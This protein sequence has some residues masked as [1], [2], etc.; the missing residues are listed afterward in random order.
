MTYQSIL[1]TTR[2]QLQEF[3]IENP[4]LE[5]HEILCHCSGLTKAELFRDLSTEISESVVTEIQA[6]VK[7]RLQNEPLA[8]L[9]EEW[10]FYGLTLKVTP[11]VLIP[12]IDSE[13]IA[14]RGIQLAGKDPT[15][16]VLDL[17]A[18]SGCLGLSIAKNIPTASVVLGD[19]S[20]SALKICRE[21]IQR[22]Q[23]AQQVAY[24]QLDCLK[25]PPVE[26]QE[27][28]SLIVCNPPYIP[29]KDISKLSPMVA[30]YEPLLALDGGEDGLHFYR[31]IVQHWLQV[32]KPTGYILFE[33]GIHQSLMVESLLEDA[34]IQVLETLSDTQSIL[35]VVQGYKPAP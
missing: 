21:N 28:F 16:R 20:I 9:L 22:T 4:T 15:G 29:T 10:D 25:P 11:D 34:G 32:L 26:L 6:L 13:I 31:S 33:V 35:R 14:L 3:E 23:V 7:R 5:C 8:Y 30:N 12:R 2:K 27:A 19:C 1:Q 24:I 18:G 17:C